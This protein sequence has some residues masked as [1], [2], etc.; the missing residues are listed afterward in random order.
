MLAQRLPRWRNRQRQ[1]HGRLFG[2]ARTGPSYLALPS[3]LACWL[4]PYSLSVTRR[5]IGETLAYN[6]LHGASGTFHVIYAEPNTIAIAKIELREIAVQM[7]FAAM[8]VD[9]LIP[10]LKIE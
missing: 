1:D 3:F 2:T 8:L 6:P 10:R 9:S 7:L 5:R 4:L